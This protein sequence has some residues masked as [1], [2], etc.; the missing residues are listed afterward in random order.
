MAQ[1]KLSLSS[2]G[3]LEKITFTLHFRRHNTNRRALSTYHLLT[4]SAKYIM[5]ILLYKKKTL[6]KMSFNNYIGILEG[7]SSNHR[8]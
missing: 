5:I 7:L 3:S 8:T 6:D 2:R 1:R 4:A